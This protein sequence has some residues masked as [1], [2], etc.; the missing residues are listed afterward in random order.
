MSKN[1]LIIHG[2]PVNDSFIDQLQKVYIASAS[3]RGANIRQLVLRDLNFEINFREGYRGNQELEPDLIAA[4]ED[5]SW[6]DHLVFFYP[7]WWG[8]YPALLKGFIDRTFLPD[9]AFRYKSGRTNPDRLLKGKT[10]RLIVTMDSPKWYYY[11]VQFAP[12]H[13]AMRMALLHFVGIKPVKV[14]TLGLLRKADEKRR[15]SWLK[16]IKKMGDRLC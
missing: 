16:M 14:T 11:L 7:N 5:I 6:A 1:I 12:G 2:H 15:A 9:F 8:T 13:H 10:A 3:A 4:Q